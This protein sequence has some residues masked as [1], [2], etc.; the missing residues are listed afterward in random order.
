MHKFLLFLLAS[1]FSIQPVFADHSMGSSKDCGM[2]AKACL[3]AGYAEK[4]NAKKKFWM[5]CMKPLLLGKTVKDVT[6]DAAIIKACRTDK[7]NDLKQELNELENV[8]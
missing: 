2:V 6:I 5:D 1:I 3:H 4:H 7:I 8:T